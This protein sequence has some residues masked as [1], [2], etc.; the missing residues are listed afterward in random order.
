MVRVGFD[1]L[2]QPFHASPHLLE[3]STRI[4]RVPP[5]FVQQLVVA[6]DL[7]DVFSQAGQQPELKRRK[8][9]T[10]LPRFTLQATKSISSSPT[11]AMFT[12]VDMMSSL[13]A[14]LVAV[15]ART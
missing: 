7:P 5:D 11:Q 12:E 2:P 8:L 3:C 9:T 14:Y 13:S 10:R 1:L 6:D 15:E 4:R